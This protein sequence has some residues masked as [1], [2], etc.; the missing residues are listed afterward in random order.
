VTRSLESN[1][2]SLP[3]PLGARALLS[4]V[5][6]PVALSNAS[7]SQELGE[8][9]SAASTPPR[10]G[11]ALRA[12][13]GSPDLELGSDLPRYSPSKEVE[14]SAMRAVLSSN[15]RDSRKRHADFSRLSLEER[16]ANPRALRPHA[17]IEQSR[18][19]D[20][21]PSK[22]G[23]LTQVHAVAVKNPIA[24]GVTAMGGVDHSR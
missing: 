1:L 9:H 2:Q 13:R 16:R 6:G 17:G 22:A 10:R 12:A 21:T 19:G 7:R 11:L 3:S 8:E 4:A 23:A 14:E 24:M 15:W 18:R 20:R 5:F